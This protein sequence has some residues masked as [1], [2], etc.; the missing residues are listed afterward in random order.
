[1]LTYLTIEALRDRT[2]LIFNALGFVFKVCFKRHFAFKIEYT[3]KG[4][5][6]LAFSTRQ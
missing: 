5:L 4:T 6:L 2:P 1:M 3:L